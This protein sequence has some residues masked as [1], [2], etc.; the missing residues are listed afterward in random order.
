LGS[1]SG[2][3]LAIMLS[4][5][6]QNIVTPA[7]PAIARE[8]HGLEHL[9]WIVVAY[10]V[11]STTFT[12]VYG[13]LSDT[14][15]RGRLMLI[16]LGV[17]IVASVWCALAGSLTEL[18]VARAVQGL[19]GGGLMVL[20]QAMIGDFVSPRERGRVQ[21]FTSILWAA[22]S[23]GG[24]VLGGFFVDQLSWRYVFWINI[25]IGIV[26]FILCRRAAAR[27]PAAHLRRPIDAT[28]ATLLVG[29]VTALLFVASSVGTTSTWTSP[30]ILGALAAG[31]VLVTAF[32]AWERRAREPLLPGRLFK[33]GTIRLVAMLMFLMSVMLFA[34]IVMLP[35]FFQLVM[36]IGAGNSGALLIPLLL[37]STMSSFAAG[38]IMRKTGRY[39]SI[40]PAS[41]A[42]GVV[43]FGLLATLQ[44]ATPLVLASLYMVVLGISVG[45]NYPVFMTSAQNV[46]DPGDLGA[47]TS[48]VVFFR[49]LG[50]AAGAA[51]FW[52]ILLAALSQH[53]AAAGIAS[54]RAAIFDGVPLPLDQ[55]TAIEGALLHAFHVAFWWACGVAATGFVLGFF[56]EETPLRTTIARRPVPAGP[57][58]PSCLPAAKAS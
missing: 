33:L 8:L 54:A 12:P 7:L 38:Q 44:P 41:F 15:G 46:A 18:I 28:G 37:S 21:A 31:A 17:F 24:P 4:A 1:L 57:P 23:I 5:L 40:V 22:S 30:A 20:A 36:H 26:A 19:G 42:A 3:M 56:L 48:A 52:S 45:A 10:L 49:A 39:K 6:D 55:R 35:V 13:K 25:P 43:G 11:T 29:G 58:Q 2:V 16:A 14:Y 27:L 9:S 50:S 51:I 32:I 53:L 34:A 47:A